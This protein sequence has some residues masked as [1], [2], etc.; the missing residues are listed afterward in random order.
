VGFTDSLRSELIH[1]KSSVQLTAVHLPAVNTPQFDWARN[2]LSRR[3][4]PLPPIFEPELIADAVHHAAYHPRREYWLG[5]PAVKAIVGQKL[6]PG[7][8]D[9]MLASEAWDGQMTE[10]T[11]QD[12]PDNLFESVPGDYA[13]R[14]R[15]SDRATDSS[16]IIWADEHR[17]ATTA[18]GAFVALALVGAAIGWFSTSR[19]QD[20][21]GRI[22]QG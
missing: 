7:I 11:A 1:D 13:A 21:Q 2:K 10:E 5:Y 19:R 12:R 14:G 3:P 22:M 18:I 20:H 15:F 8:A 6:V 4:Q 9:H 16:P 17:R